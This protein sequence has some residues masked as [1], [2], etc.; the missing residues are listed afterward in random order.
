MAVLLLCSTPVPL[1]SKQPSNLLQTR[2]TGGT[3]STGSSGQGWSSSGQGVGAS[4]GVAVKVWPKFNSA[5]I[6]QLQQLML[7]FLIACALPLSLFQNPD[8]QAMILGLAPYMATHLPSA[9]QFSTT[10]L[11]KLFETERKRVAQWL[12]EQ[13]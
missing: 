2:L 8:A 7:T 13:V 12:S 9:N 5:E 11:D 3:V 10:Q 4:S 6:E 1:C